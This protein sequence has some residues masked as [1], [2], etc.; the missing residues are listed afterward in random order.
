MAT[1]VVP[2]SH[3]QALDVRLGSLGEHVMG[4]MDAKLREAEACEAD[5]NAIL[6]DTALFHAGPATGATPRVLLGFGLQRTNLT[7]RVCVCAIG[8]REAFVLTPRRKRRP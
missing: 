5:A 4:R 7:A 3:R 1:L 8:G 2:G 6:F